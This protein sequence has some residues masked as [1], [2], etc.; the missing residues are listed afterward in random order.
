[1]S[2]SPP[3]VS[4]VMP[5]YN[6]AAFLDETVA[7]VLAQTLTDFELLIIDDG[8]QDES[9]P[10]AE[11]WAARDARIKVLTHPGHD[12]RGCSATRNRGL[13]KTRADL[14]AFIDADD[15]WPTRKLAHQAA[16]FAQ[17]SELGLVGG[18]AI[19]W[20]SW[21]GGEDWLVVAGH[22]MDSIVPRGEANLLTYPLGKAQAPCPST[23]MVRRT[24]I[25]RI[26]GFEEEFHGP[27]Q[28]YEDQAFLAKCYIE[29]PVY[30]ASETYCHYRQHDESIVASVVGSGRY[31]E[32]RSYFLNWFEA[33]LDR[34][35]HDHRAIRRKLKHAKMR[36]GSPMERWLSK[37]FMRQ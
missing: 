32:V 21:E 9:F 4:I 16:L 7:S 28:L 27:L 15:T 6:G 22:K 5:L 10:L 3:A 30:F 8:S 14:I 24:L 13:G 2:T 31:D 19:Y 37:T 36:Y 20:D 29:A 34:R 11:A 26:G 33:Y 35:D 17:H 25:D 1:M 12:N 23:L 18:A